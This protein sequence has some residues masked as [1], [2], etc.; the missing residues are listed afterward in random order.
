MQEP[1][2]QT[3]AEE[4][5]SGIVHGLAVLALLA[6]TPFLILAAAERGATAVAGVSVFA[7]TALLLYF[8]STM[9]HLLPNG[10]A[11]TLFDRFDHCAIFLLIAGTYTPFSLTALMGWQGW[12]LFGMIWGAAVVGIVSTLFPK[13]CNHWV[14]L[15]LYLGMGWMVLLFIRPMCAHLGW[16]GMSWLIGGGAAYSLGVFFYA[17]SGPRYWHCIWHVFTVAG[18]A[19]HFFAILWYVVGQRTVIP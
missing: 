7:A 4:W 19:C 18:T 3:L 16:A 10:S 13:L 1:R 12:T 8:C 15:T 6:G 14:K 2:E 9:Y 17:N 5:A 11:K